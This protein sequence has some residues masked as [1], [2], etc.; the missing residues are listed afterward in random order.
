VAVT[1]KAA[2]TVTT[3]HAPNTAAFSQA[4]LIIFPLQG[5]LWNLDGT[6]KNTQ[7]I[8]FSG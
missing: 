7:M 5:R 1:T 2:K 8:P 6:W 4:R 3:A